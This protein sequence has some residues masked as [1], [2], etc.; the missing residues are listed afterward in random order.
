M[1][2][3]DFNGDG[4]GDIVVGA[5]GARDGIGRAYIVYGNASGIDDDFDLSAMENSDY[6]GLVLSSGDGGNFSHSIGFAVAAAGYVRDMLQSL[7]EGT[8]QTAHN[9]PKDKKKRSTTYDSM[10]PRPHCLRPFPTPGCNSSLQAFACST[11]MTQNHSL[12]AA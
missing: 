5:P 9:R 8:E 7:F 1:Y 2:T 4:V 10:T 11:T 3:A 6:A 12:N